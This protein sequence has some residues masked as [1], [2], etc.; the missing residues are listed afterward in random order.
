MTRMLQIHRFVR[1]G[2]KCTCLIRPVGSV[3]ATVIAAGSPASIPGSKYSEAALE[4]TPEMTVRAAIMGMERLR[5]R[6]T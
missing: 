5:R 2:M 4:A 1:V 3:P 6:F